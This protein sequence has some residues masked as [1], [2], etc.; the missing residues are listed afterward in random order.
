[1]KSLPWLIAGFV[2]FVGMAVF[3]V[4]RERRR[5]LEEQRRREEIARH[6]SI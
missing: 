4:R 2:F 5:K 1:M 6:R 3:E